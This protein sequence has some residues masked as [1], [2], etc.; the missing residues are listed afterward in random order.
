MK[1][2]SVLISFSFCSAFALGS[3]AVLGE[4]TFTESSAVALTIDHSGDSVVHGA[5]TV[6]IG[7]SD[8]LL[9]PETGF[10]LA[11]FPPTIPDRPWH[12]DAWMV[13]NCLD[14]HETGVQDA[15]RIRHEGLPDIA[16]QSKC[17][18]CHVLIPG[19]TDYTPKAEDSEYASWA[20]PPMM[21]NNQK[22]EQAWGKKNCLLCHEDGTQNAP[23]V[24]HEGMPKIILKAK[25]RTCHVQIRSHTTS[26]WDESWYEPRVD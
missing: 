9:D 24:K 11:A 25:C 19:S 17:R 18:T 15:P 21:P 26:P 7:D 22:H 3:W 13:N 10:A 23:I 12:K 2:H 16:Y 20:F 8:I 14:C 4:P 5:P 1:L 6:R